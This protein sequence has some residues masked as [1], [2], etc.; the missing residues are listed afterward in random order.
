[1]DFFLRIQHIIVIVLLSDR[2][3][4]YR[5]SRTTSSL[6]APSLPLELCDCK[7]ISTFSPHYAAFEGGPLPIKGWFVHHVLFMFHAA[8]KSINRYHITHELYFHGVAMLEVDPLI[9]SQ[10]KDPEHKTP[11]MLRTLCCGQKR[12]TTETSGH[13]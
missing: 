5:A 8:M 7:R 3:L 1:M 2:V 12:R 9:T 13:R 11:N 4:L 10:R 6:G